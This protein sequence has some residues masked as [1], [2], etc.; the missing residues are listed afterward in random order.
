MEKK[1]KH[2]EKESIIEK[3]KELEK[4]ASLYQQNIKQY[5]KLRKIIFDK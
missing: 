3:L 1:E 4:E 5:I 2:T